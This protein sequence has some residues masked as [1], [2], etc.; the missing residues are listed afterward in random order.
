MGFISLTLTGPGL[1]TDRKIM[2][3]GSFVDHFYICI[4]SKVVNKSLM[5]G[6]PGGLIPG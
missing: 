5:G 6:I 2:K 3:T 1:N 4:V